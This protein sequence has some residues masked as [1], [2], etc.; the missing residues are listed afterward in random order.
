[1]QRQIQKI[2]QHLHIPVPLQKHMLYAASLGY[3]IAH[4]WRIKNTINHDIIITSLLCHDLGNLVKFD[5]TSD[6]TKQ[7][8]TAKQI[9]NLQIIQNNHIKKFG[10]NEH[11]ATA[12]IC[13]SLNLNAQI[14]QTIDSIRFEAQKAVQSNNWNH[15]ICNYCD[16][17]IAPQGL[18]SLKQRLKDLMIRYKHEYTQIDKQRYFAQQHKLKQ[19]LEKQIQNNCLLQLNKLE[20]KDLPDIIEKLKQYEIP[21]NFFIK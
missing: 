17:R 5:L 2:Y 11:T 9:E 3:L 1:M 16:Y 15:K 10:E 19:K 20:V 8:Y 14:L 6:L 18:T 12:N 21:N 13:Q 7:M 4:N